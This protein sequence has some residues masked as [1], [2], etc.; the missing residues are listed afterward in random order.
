MRPRNLLGT[1]A[2]FRVSLTQQPIRRFE[3]AVDEREHR[4]LVA[5]EVQ[6]VRHAGSA[7]PSR[8]R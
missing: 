7:Q 8:R 5:T 4:R 1:V 3:H 6:G 2:S